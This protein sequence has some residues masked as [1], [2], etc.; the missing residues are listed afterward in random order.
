[1]LICLAELVLT[2]FLSDNVESRL[3]AHFRDGLSA[4]QVSWWSDGDFNDDYDGDDGDSG[5]DG[6][7]DD[8][9]DDGCQ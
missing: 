2:R 8:G 5:D 9:G 7:D 6:G 1:V 3:G 4:L